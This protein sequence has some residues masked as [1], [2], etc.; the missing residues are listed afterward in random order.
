MNTISLFAGNSR[1]AMRD[2]A[3]FI[4]ECLLPCGYSFNW[5]ADNSELEVSGF[6]HEHYILSDATTYGLSTEPIED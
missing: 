1:E 2:L 5:C 3:A 4:A 6:I